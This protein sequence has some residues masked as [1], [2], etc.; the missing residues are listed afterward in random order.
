[1]EYWVRKE[2]LWDTDEQDI[3]IYGKFL[4]AGIREN[5]RPI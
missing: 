4:S 5:L 2:L 1:M 3:K